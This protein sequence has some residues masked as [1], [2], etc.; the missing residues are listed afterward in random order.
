MF[1]IFVL[2][3]CI[4]NKKWRPSNKRIP[5]HM[6]V[7]VTELTLNFD[8][9]TRPE[10]LPHIHTPPKTHTNIE[11]IHTAMAQ[12]STTSLPG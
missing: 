6:H 12:K 1:K 8:E 3:E 11:H 4:A 7:E 2:Y 5:I 10:E 9:R